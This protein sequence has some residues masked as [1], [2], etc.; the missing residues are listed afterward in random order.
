MFE[1]A[2]R[3]KLRFETVRG[4]VSVEDLWDL[5]LTSKS[6]M[7]L[8]DVAKALNRNLDMLE[9]EDF[10][11]APDPQRATYELAFNIVKHIIAV[12]QAEAQAKTDAAAKRARAA[13]IRDIL[14]QKADAALQSMDESALKAELAAL[15]S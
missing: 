8:N 11:G 13:K 10:V 12:R 7:S 2:T 14:D 15:E 3:I 6:G 4:S 9:E 1:K 5:P